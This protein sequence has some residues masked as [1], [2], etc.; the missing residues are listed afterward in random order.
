MYRLSSLGYLDVW[1]ITISNGRCIIVLK[2]K[3]CQS[4]SQG[5]CTILQFPLEQ[6]ENSSSSTS[7]HSIVSLFILAI[8][9][10]NSI[11]LNFSICIFPTD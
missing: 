5:S 10:I 2:K 4:I 9:M 3:T 11:S 6:Y 7:L 1:N 8:H